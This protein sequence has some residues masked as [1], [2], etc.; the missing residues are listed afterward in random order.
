MSVHPQPEGL[1]R[2]LLDPGYWRNRLEA[3]GRVPRSL[4]LFP[5]PDLGHPGVEVLELHL[6]GHD[7]HRLR[8]VL[9]R[10]V[11]RREGTSTR[12]RLATTGRSEE[13]DW[14]RIEEGAA[15]LVFES[16][17]SRRLE[18]RVLDVLR[19]V[20]CAATLEGLE[21]ERIELM[22]ENRREAADELLIAQALRDEHL[23]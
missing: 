2:L 12:L 15:D 4:L 1:H 3:M 13:L 10:S 6:R 17:V 9:A 16:D 8:A 19:L 18:D 23:C 5:R 22:P 11:F 14:S 20:T 21:Q 7:G